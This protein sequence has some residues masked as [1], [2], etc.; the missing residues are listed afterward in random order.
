MVNGPYWAKIDKIIDL[1][2]TL[3][4]AAGISIMLL[5]AGM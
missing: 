5:V 2:Y 4:T 1:S 3:Y